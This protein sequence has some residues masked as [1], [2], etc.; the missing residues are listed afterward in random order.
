[1]PGERPKNLCREKSQQEKDE[2]DDEPRKPEGSRIRIV[3]RAHE[4]CPADSHQHDEKQQDEQPIAGICETILH[5]PKIAD[6]LV[7]ICHIAST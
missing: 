7:G 4:V 5:T 2:P 6:A 1:M 3:V